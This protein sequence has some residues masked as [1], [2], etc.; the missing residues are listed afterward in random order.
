M[1]PTSIED[2]LIAIVQHQTTANTTI[3]NGFRDVVSVL[4]NLVDR[5]N[6]LEAEVDR[7]GKV[8]DYLMKRPN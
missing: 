8:I 3:S 6:S 2:A 4:E 1:T 7:Q 5:I